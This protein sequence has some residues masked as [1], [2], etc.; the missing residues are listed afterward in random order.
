[1]RNLLIHVAM[2]GTLAALGLALGLH[3]AA[4]LVGVLVLARLTF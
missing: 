1:M 3:P 4:I 2:F